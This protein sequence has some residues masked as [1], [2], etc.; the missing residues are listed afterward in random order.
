MSTKPL[1]ELWWTHARRSLLPSSLAAS[2]KGIH[3]R[4]R[5]AIRPERSPVGSSS[6]TETAGA[7]MIVI[8][9][10]AADC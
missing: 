6:G 3:A 7:I 1:S 9:I 4:R 2:A 10:R 5:R 8:G